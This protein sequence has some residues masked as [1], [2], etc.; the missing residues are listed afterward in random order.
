MSDGYVCVLFRDSVFKIHW[1]MAALAYT[2]A[3]SLLF[4]SVSITQS[5][6][7]T[8]PVL[9]SHSL[10]TSA[11]L[12]SDSLIAHIHLQDV[13]CQRSYRSSRSSRRRLSDVQDLDW[14]LSFK[15]HLDVFTHQMFCRS[16]ADYYRHTCTSC[17]ASHHHIPCD[18]CCQPLSIKSR[19][20][21][22]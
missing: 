1:L 9:S 20:F 3:I 4:H 16:L 8:Q 19:C 7:L 10:Y 17:A 12:A 2:K 13:S 15:R 5:S 18:Q 6:D 11:W 21:A 22:S 14:M